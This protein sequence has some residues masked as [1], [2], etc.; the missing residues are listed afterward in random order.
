MYIFEY[1]KQ[2][3]NTFHIQCHW[4]EPHLIWIIN[5]LSRNRKDMERA[6]REVA[7]ERG[8][9]KKNMYITPGEK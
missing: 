4:K 1:D 6:E 8:I 2:H 7:G 9:R 3:S 5:S